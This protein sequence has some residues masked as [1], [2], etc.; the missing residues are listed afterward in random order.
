MVSML[1]GCREGGSWAMRRLIV[2]ALAT[3]EK[4]HVSER[5]SHKEKGGLGVWE[6]GWKQDDNER[7]GESARQ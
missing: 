5:Q 1:G 4:G 6:R 7:E 3:R 2:L